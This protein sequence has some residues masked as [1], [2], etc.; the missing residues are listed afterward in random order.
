MIIVLKPRTSK[1]EESAVIAEIRRLGYRPHIMR[2]VARTVIGAI[3]DERTHS[4]LETLTALPQVESV[5]PIQK[6]FKLVS[7]EAHPANSTITLRNGCVIGG[8]EL[9]IMAGPCSVESEKQLL[10]TAEAV[11]KAGAK[12]LRGGAFKPRTS[13]YEFQ[14]LGEKGLKLLSKARR[15]TG[16][17]VITELLSEAHAEVVAEHA[18][19]L[20]IGTRNAQN[21]ELLK[22]VGQSRKPV[23]L[24][25]GLAMTI[26]I[27][28]PKDIHP[29]NKQEVGRRLSLVARHL[30]YG[31]KDLVYSGPE[32]VEMQTEPP[33]HD[34]IRLY[35]KHVHGGLMIKPGDEKLTGFVIAGTDK[36]FVFA[37]A[38][39]EGDTIVVSS[40]E[41]PLPK[42]VRYGWAWNPL[43][44]LYNKE[45]LPAITFRTDE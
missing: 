41:V 40:P 43:V 26:D 23:M 2:G 30:V 5:M 11:A 16:L 1:R 10:H 8:H 28:D 13:P 39:I 15:E 37:D 12:V 25:R 35:F 6:R 34:K 20:Q 4:T 42:Y 24:K 19:I 22:E 31:E 27:G 44:N 21:F 29:R 45:G 3:G 17:A 7:R 38:V 32:F 14:G 18:D 9:V 33:K 36:N